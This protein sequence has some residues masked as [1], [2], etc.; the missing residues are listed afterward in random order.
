MQ[1]IKQIKNK[2]YTNK[3]IVGIKKKLIIIIALSPILYLIFG[4]LKWPIYD[5]LL[6]NYSSKIN[7]T[8]INE[9][10][11][12]GKGVI[13]EMFTYSYEFSVNGE[14]YSGDSRKSGYKVGNK[15]KIEYLDFCPQINRPDRAEMSTQ[16]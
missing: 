1:K 3:I 5:T 2:N 13:T 6:D 14:I 12:L 16:R 7:A 15:I 9:R 8:I 4:I 10:N 11:I